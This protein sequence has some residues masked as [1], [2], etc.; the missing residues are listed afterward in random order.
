MGRGVTAKKKK[1]W[2]NTTPVWHYQKLI[3]SITCIFSPFVITEILCQT[4]FSVQ[5]IPWT[6]PSSTAFSFDLQSCISDSLLDMF[7]LSPHTQV[8]NL[9]HKSATSSIF[10]VFASDPIVLSGAQVQTCG[11]IILLIFPSQLV[12]KFSLIFFLLNIAHS[13]FLCFPTAPTPV[14]SEHSM[15]GIISR[16]SQVTHSSI[17]F[18]PNSFFQIKST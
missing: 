14:Q 11:V 17:H 5:V 18:Q 16:A 4:F 10:S 2:K 8:I 6:V 7:P 9:L 1:R 13:S 3:P 15:A 12:T